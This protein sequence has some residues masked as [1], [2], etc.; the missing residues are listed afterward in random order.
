MLSVAD[1]ATGLTDFQEALQP[2]VLAAERIL[3]AG[4]GQ[5]LLDYAMAIG[6]MFG[7]VESY[8]ADQYDGTPGWSVMLDPDRCPTPGLPY[9]AQWVGERLPTGISD[10]PNSSNPINPATGLG[11]SDARQWIIDTPNQY[12]GTP[13]SIVRAAQRW[14][15]GG[16][17]VMIQ[18][19]WDLA[20]ASANDDYLAVQVYANQLPTG[21]SEAAAIEL[22][23]TELRKVVPADVT[24]QFAV[25]TGI[26]W[27]ALK[28]GGFGG[29][30]ANPTWA[31]VKAHYATWA[32]VA[33]V[34]AGYT[35]W[36]R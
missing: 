5:D 8:A 23:S 34:E 6:L 2:Q 30:P 19:R 36:T 20:T 27:E 24:I 31:Q 1:P 15:T 29:L 18:E 33:G 13:M 11:R 4:G 10:L 14:L 17:L 28:L 7:E 26:T 21:M 22:I 16:K 12:R 25:V 3:G 9:L 35:S 32:D